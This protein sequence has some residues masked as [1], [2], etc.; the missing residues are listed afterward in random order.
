MRYLAKIIEMSLSSQ[1]MAK[2]TSP[3]RIGPNNLNIS[4]YLNISYNLSFIKR[5]L[6]QT[7]SNW[8][9]GKEPKA[10]VRCHP[11][12]T[13]P[14]SKWRSSSL[15]VEEGRIKACCSLKSMWKSYLLRVVRHFRKKN[16]ELKQRLLTTLTLQRDMLN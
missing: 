4:L 1:S 13:P 5:A 15:G 3:H 9:W 8:P 10:S 7:F 16:K 14:L 6:P 12:Q 11:H 2:S